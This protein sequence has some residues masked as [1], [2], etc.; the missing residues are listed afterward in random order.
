MKDNQVVL[1]LKECAGIHG[2]DSISGNITD[3]GTDECKLSDERGSV[4]G[5]AVK[6]TDPED[7]K[8]ILK[9]TDNPRK[10]KDWRTIGE[11]YYPLYWGIDVN[12]GSRLDAHTKSSDSTGTIQLNKKDYLKD[13]EII[14]GGILCNNRGAVEKKLREEYPDVLKTSKGI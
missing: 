2:V 14:Y 9:Y 13:M 1:I 3:V 12:L 5:I 7:V 4:Y 8:K 10:I 6:I 11:D